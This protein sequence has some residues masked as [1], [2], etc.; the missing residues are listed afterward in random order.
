MPQQRRGYGSRTLS[1]TQFF[2]AQADGGTFPPAWAERQSVAGA[3]PGC[4]GKPIF[5]A[6]LGPVGGSFGPGT[7][8]R[9]RHH[10]PKLWF[11]IELDWCIELDFNLYCTVL[12][13]ACAWGSADRPGPI[14][15][16]LRCNQVRNG[17]ASEFQNGHF[18]PGI[19]GVKSF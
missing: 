1:D 18:R 13:G 3:G 10:C 7:P 11:C 14:A 15:T 12:F 6:R 4:V 16:R 2:A 19:F 17:S 9:R 8:R 5:R